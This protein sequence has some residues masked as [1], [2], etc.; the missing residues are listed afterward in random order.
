MLYPSNRLRQPSVGFN[1]QHEYMPYPEKRE[2]TSFVGFNQDN[3]FQ[4]TAQ[5]DTTP[6]QQSWNMPAH[7]HAEQFNPTAPVFHGMKMEPALNQSMQFPPRVE[8]SFPMVPQCS[9]GYPAL[10]SR[11]QNQDYYSQGQTETEKRSARPLAQT[12]L[13]QTKP[14]WL[15]KSLYISE[16]STWAEFYRKFLNY[17]RDKHWSSQECKTN[18]GY[19]IEG[20]AAE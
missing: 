12:T 14:E 20:S 19:V 15:P 5:S 4:Q 8:Q 9:T 17:A 16:S 6:L 3:R 18:I 2:P 10:G 11:L 7:H 1:P 13:K